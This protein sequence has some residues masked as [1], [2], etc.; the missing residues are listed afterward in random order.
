MAVFIVIK[1]EQPASYNG[2]TPQEYLARVYPHVDPYSPEGKAF[3]ESMGLGPPVISGRD[4]VKSFGDKM[5]QRAAEIA[6][7]QP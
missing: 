2:S 6:R 4:I 1:S 5:D 3:L 7:N